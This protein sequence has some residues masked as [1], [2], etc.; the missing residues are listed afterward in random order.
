MHHGVNGD[1]L[2]NEGSIGGMGARKGMR[3]GREC[4]ME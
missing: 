3:L 1:G 2:K 4:V